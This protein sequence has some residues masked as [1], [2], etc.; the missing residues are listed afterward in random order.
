MTDLYPIS[1]RGDD[2]AHWDARASL[3]AREAMRRSARR[4]HIAIAQSRAPWIAAS[5]L[6]AAALVLMVASARAPAE[7][8]AAELRLAVAPADDVGRALALPEQPP[9][10]ATLLLD[11]RPNAPP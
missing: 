2:D 11:P 6:F 10:I 8:S 9:A 5:L 1:T 7:S 3:V 4:G